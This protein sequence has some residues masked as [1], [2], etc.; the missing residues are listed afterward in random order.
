M[1]ARPAQRSVL[2]PRILPLAG[3]HGPRVDGRQQQRASR[4]AAMSLAQKAN[5]VQRLEQL[6]EPV[7]RP[8][9]LRLRVSP[10]S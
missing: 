3:G 1:R 6:R 2:D 9:P 4:V 5:T 7:K 10:S 8:P